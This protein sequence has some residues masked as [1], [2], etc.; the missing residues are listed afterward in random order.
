[1]L[2]ASHTHSSRLRVVFLKQGG[3]EADLNHFK[4]FKSFKSLFNH[5]NSLQKLCEIVTATNI[6]KTCHAYILLLDAHVVL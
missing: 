3:K 5:F 6:V 4:S 1:M 2:F